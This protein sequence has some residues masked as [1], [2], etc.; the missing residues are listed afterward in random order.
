MGIQLIDAAKEGRHL[1][2]R[3]LLAM[4]A[5]KDAMDRDGCTPVY[6]ACLRGNLATD[7]E[8]TQ[9]G[10]DL[11]MANSVGRSKRITEE[12]RWAGVTLCLFFCPP[13]LCSSSSPSSP[14]RPPSTSSFRPYVSSLIG[15]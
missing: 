8:L 15:I 2:V 6:W 10:A 5:D 4:G 13:P 14:P 1:T 7:R 9:A 3:G 12:K 11:E